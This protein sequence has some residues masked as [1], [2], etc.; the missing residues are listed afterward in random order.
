MKNQLLLVLA[1][2]PFLS[3]G[4]IT[5]L[6]DINLGTEDSSPSEFFVDS[7]NRLFFQANNGTDGNELYI[8]DGSTTTLIDINTAGSSNSNPKYFIEFGSKIYFRASDDAFKTELWVTDG[9]S[10]NT[11]LVADI[12]TSGPSSPNHLFV[13]DGELYFTVLDGTSTQIWALNGET[14]TKFTTNNSGGF[15]SPAYPHVTA[16]GVYMRVNDGNGNEPAFFDGTGNATEIIDIGPGSGMIVMSDEENIELLG[17]KLFFEAD[18]SGSDDEMWVS[19]GTAVG[20]FQVGFTNPSGAGDPDYFEVHQGDMFFGSE[21][22]DGYQLWKSDGTVVGTVLVSDMNSGGNG[23]VENLYSDGT[24][25]YFSATN[26]TDG[27]ELWIYDGTSASM[28]K[29]INSTGD[30]TPDNF[31]AL[32]GK[33]FFTADDGSG[34]KLWVT[35]GTSGGTESVAASIGSGEDPTAVD[36]LIIRDGKLIFSGASVTNGNELF[37]LDPVTLSTKISEG[38]I[39]RVFP[40]PA[41]DYIMVSKQLLNAPYSIH[42]ITGKIVKQD[43][44]TSE[45][46]NLDLNSGLYLFKIK[47]DLS[48]V[49]KKIIIK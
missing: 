28:L 44:I 14:P 40:N 30:S 45:K 9:T 15:A 38:E 26:G 1:L 31:I 27:E 34:I 18:S 20:T 8:Y 35:D 10:V 7:S 16:T 2:F 3:M 32:D 21:D 39:V 22:A 11:S 33:V 48:T 41:N 49:T 13:F 24:N 29:D 6:V 23:A 25:L 46:I 12:N 5:E 47:T 42:D 37:T 19:D 4:Q 43:I 36:E 17:N